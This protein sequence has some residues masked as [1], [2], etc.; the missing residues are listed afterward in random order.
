MV[1]PSSPGKQGRG[2]QLGVIRDPGASRFPLK[3]TF[4]PVENW[5]GPGAFGFH[6]IATLPNAPN[7][8]DIYF[9]G[10]V[11]R[12]RH[13]LVGLTTTGFQAFPPPTEELLLALLYSRAK[14]HKL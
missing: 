11:F 9:D 12:I 7:G 1:T 8:G 10:F 2:R 5:Y 4:E 3:T 14:A 6:A 13:A